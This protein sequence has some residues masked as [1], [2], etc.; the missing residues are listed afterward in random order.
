MDIHSVSPQTLKR[1]PMYLRFLT[2]VSTAEYPNISATAIADALGYYDVQVRKDLASVSSGGRPKTGYIT[3]NLIKDIKKFLGYDKQKYAV[4]VGAGN[5]G[6]ALLSYD[7]FK[8]YGLEISAGFDTDEKLWGECIHGKEIFSPDYMEEYCRNH[9]ITF[10]IIASTSKSAQ[11][12]ADKLVKIGV[13]SILNFAP[14]NLKVP[15]D[16]MVENVDIASSVV[17]LC[18]HITGTEN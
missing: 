17:L 18:C 9:S 14:V 15:E 10:G 2:S 1:L 8:K 13:K 16:V 4:L 7:G 5:L 12:I 3:E 6:H 11:D